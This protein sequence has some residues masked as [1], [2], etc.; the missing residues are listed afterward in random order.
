M[1]KVDLQRYPYR[2][3]V[4]EIAD[5]LGKALP[6][7]HEALFKLDVPN[8]EYAALFNRKLEERQRIIRKFKKN[9]QGAK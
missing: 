1:E 5:E 9:I 6:N 8:P 2:G 4:K 3:I 7:V